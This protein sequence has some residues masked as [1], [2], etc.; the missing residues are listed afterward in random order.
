[1]GL[2]STKNFS[3][4]W[5]ARTKTMD[6]LDEPPSVSDAYARTYLWSL[7]IQATTFY[8]PNPSYDRRDSGRCQSYS[9]PSSP[10][11]ESFGFGETMAMAV[12][13]SKV[14]SEMVRTAL[15]F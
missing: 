6:A 5:I 12:T 3:L 9:A 11:V 14:S 15:P 2:K 7:K 8:D 4:T 1:M 10:E 13:E